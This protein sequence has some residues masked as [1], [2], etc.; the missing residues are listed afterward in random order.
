V[1]Q[2]NVTGTAGDDTINAQQLQVNGFQLVLDGGAGND[3]LTGGAGNDVLLGGAGDDFVDGG[4]G[5]DTAILGSGNDTF[6]WN[7]GEGSDVVEG[8]GGF[9]TLQFNGS[10]AGENIN[11]GANGGRVLMTRD[12]ANISMDVNGLEQINFAALGGADNINVADLSGTD[13]K[14]VH[15]DLAAI[16]GTGTGDGL[17]DNVTVNGTSG[18]DTIKIVGSA[19]ETI[20]SGLPAETH[21]VGADSG[22]D[23]VHVT[24]GGG[25]DVIDASAVTPG[26][27][28]LILDGGIGNDKIIGSS[29]NDTVLWNPGDGS[30]VVEGHGGFDTLQFNGSTGAENI[31]ISS[32]GSRVLLSRDV[33]QVT[34]DLH[35][36]AQIN[37]TANGGADNVNVADLTGTDVKQVH[38]DLSAPPGSGIGDSLV[39]NVTVNATASAEVVTLT[40]NGSETIVGGL[41]AE[42]HVNHAESTDTI[43][44]LAGAG[45]DIIDAS[46]VIAGGA[47][48]VLN[49]GDGND[50][51]VGSAGDDVLIGG[52][53]DDILIG[54]G[55]HDVFDG[56]S[57]NNVILNFSVTSDQ[58]DLRSLAGGH[59]ADWALAQA[60]DVDGNVVFNF[61]DQ[62]VTLMHETVAGLN[63]SDFLMA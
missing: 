32:H 59:S 16:S 27:A 17:A 56:G 46:A 35:G 47:K 52:A 48:L 23:T 55:G 19:A 53:G 51:I 9:D 1:E 40:S 18:N 33:G 13:V 21:V 45:D 3:T 57:G 60:H 44:V 7:P 12:V 6:V 63:A 39:D 30:D 29:G 42:T 61:G 62:Q 5:A 8:Q 15:V 34:M 28:Q 36:V 22:L 54:N 10:N 37:V 26:G 14:Q 24:G 25:N 50:L 58:I 43:T 4:R 20:V 11:I 38:V 2:L 31:D 41:S 49:G